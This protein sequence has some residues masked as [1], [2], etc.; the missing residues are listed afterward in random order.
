LL[1]THYHPRRRLGDLDLLLTTGEPRDRLLVQACL[2]TSCH[3]R[4]GQPMVHALV[5]AVEARGLQDRV[6]VRATFC[7]ERCGEGP[8]VRVGE[9][10]VSSATVETVLAAIDEAL[11]QA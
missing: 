9:R 2:G 6:D 1:H 4:G 8:N 3:L 5:A 10:V 11:V 7:L